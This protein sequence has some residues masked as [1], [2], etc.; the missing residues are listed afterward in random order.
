MAESFSTR[1][2]WLVDER[3][4]EN[5]ADRPMDTNQLLVDPLNK[6]KQLFR[7]LR[8]LSHQPDRR[9]SHRTGVTFFLEGEGEFI[10]EAI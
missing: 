7:V 9:E 3:W 2:R 4:W 1:N 6:K 5:R 8:R 10:K